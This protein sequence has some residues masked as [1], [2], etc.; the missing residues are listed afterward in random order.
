MKRM[1]KPRKIKRRLKKRRKV[2]G[3]QMRNLPLSKLDHLKSCRNLMSSMR[4]ITKIGL[5]VTK[6]KTSSKPLIDK[7]QE[8]K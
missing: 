4:A 2:Q 8:M 6:E 3:M 1:Q 5:T 7:W